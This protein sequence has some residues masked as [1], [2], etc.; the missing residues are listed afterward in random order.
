V[1]TTTEATSAKAD[2][3][4]RNRRISYRLT[5]ATYIR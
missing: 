3:T 2:S 5:W 1:N 4:W